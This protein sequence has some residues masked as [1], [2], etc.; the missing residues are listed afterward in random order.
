[1]SHAQ[2]Q[3]LTSYFSLRTVVAATLLAISMLTACGSHQPQSQLRPGAHNIPNQDFEIKANESK[4]IVGQH[5]TIIAIPAGAF[6]DRMGN[7]VQ[8]SLTFRLKEANRDLDILV[9]DLI[10][11]TGEN[12]LASGGMYM[13]QATQNGKALQINPAVGIYASFPTDKKDP[14]MG[15][16]KGDFDDAKLDWKLTDAKEKGIP[17]CDASK[18]TQK[19]CKKCAN[20]VKMANRIKPKKKPKTSEYYAKRHYWENGV[21]YFASSGSRKPVMSQDQIEECKAYLEANEKGRELLAT[22]DQYKAEWKDRV[23]EYYQYQIYGL[24]WYNCDKLVQDELVT[25]SGQI[26]NSDGKSMPGANVHLYCP[27]TDLRVHVSTVAADGNFSLQFVPGRQFML[28]AY[29]KG[30]VAK[31]SFRLQAEKDQAITALQLKELQ[32][33]E[34]KTYLQDLM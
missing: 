32:P 27:D 4:V 9:G 19:Q 24:G 30:K 26:L 21:L 33:E 29:D 20:L 1:M 25:F 17:R 13:L 6:M 23:G 5:G 15:L 12:M 28:Y 2:A 16:Y 11:Q 8:G 18:Y 31:G 3:P 7:P 34:V 22:V 10:T 14:R